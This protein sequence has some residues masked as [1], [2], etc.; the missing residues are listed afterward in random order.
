MK[1]GACSTER[2]IQVFLHSVGR[3]G[4][5]FLDRLDGKQVITG[6]WLDTIDQEK[7]T[8]VHAY[9]PRNL[10]VNSYAYSSVVCG[11]SNRAFARDVTS[12]ILVSY[13]SPVGIE[14]FSYVN[15]FF[16]RNKFAWLLST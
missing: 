15:S 9:V 6:L 16:C 13:T 11:A 10:A 4:H 14:L 1:R 2:F 7:L 12:A 3:M 5:R 8:L